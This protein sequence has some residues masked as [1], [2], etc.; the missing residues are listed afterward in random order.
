[1]VK[2]KIASELTMVRPELEFVLQTWAKNAGQ[3]FIIT[4]SEGITV[5]TDLKSD[6]QVSTYFIQKD[7]NRI[8]L[9]KEGVVLC[10]SNRTD[11]ITT[12]FYLINSLQEHNSTDLDELGRFKF[13]NSYQFKLKNWDQNI[14]Q[15]CMDAI[16]NLACVSS[17]KAKSQFLLTHDIDMVYGSW[18]EDGFNVIKKGRFDQFAVLLLNAIFNRPDW[19]NMDKITKLESEYDCKSVFYWIVNKGK[20]NSR[21]RNADYTFHS[22]AIQKQV[23]HIEQ[24]GFENGIHKSISNETLQ[25]EI[26]KFG[27]HPLANRYH[28]LKFALPQ[29]YTNIQNAKLKLDTS[30]GFAEQPG[31]RNN[32]GLPFNPFD[33]SNRKAHTFV[34]APLHIMDRTFFQYKKASIQDTENEILAFFEKNRDNCVLSVLWHNNFFTDYKFK[35]YLSLYKKILAYIRDN[36]FKTITQKE[37]IQTF[38]I[39]DN[40]N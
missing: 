15:Y 40:G 21:E 13:A 38:S 11:Y 32:Y 25:D 26:R 28:Y 4:E 31:F 33:F 34:E 12:I 18:L 2:F 16:S 24:N 9:D 27:K 5:G 19:L 22:N 1:M 17:R 23:K 36:D 39:T 29:A 35:G 6:L 30:L 7:F 37:I 14:V 3:E 10:E 20:L 8:K